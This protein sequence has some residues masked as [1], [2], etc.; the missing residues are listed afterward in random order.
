MASR[1][2]RR[3]R[4]FA[5]LTFVSYAFVRGERVLCAGARKPSSPEYT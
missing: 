5:T 2:K 3:I 4:G 1:R